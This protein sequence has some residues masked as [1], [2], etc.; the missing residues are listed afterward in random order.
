MVVVTGLCLAWAATPNV[1]VKVD[2]AGVFLV[3]GSRVGLYARSPG[4][5][6]RLPVRIGQTV[7][8]GDLIASIDR[9]DQ[10]APGGG[11]AAANP[12]ALRRQAVALDQQIAALR[13]QIATL[14]TSNGPIGKQ[15][16]PR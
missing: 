15:L 16:R 13:S 6:Q 2:G 9:I 3:P 7:A 12:D 8:K 5:I 4:Q 10:A 11:W 1:P 14:R